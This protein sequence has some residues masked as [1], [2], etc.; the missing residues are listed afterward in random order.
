MENDFNNMHKRGLKQLKIYS[1]HYNFA[2]IC[3]LKQWG[4]GDTATLF[5]SIYLL[6]LLLWIFISDYS[7]VSFNTQKMVIGRML[8][9]INKVLI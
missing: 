2:Y 8:R 1:P 6:L 5:L 7:T 3:G 4:F 9:K